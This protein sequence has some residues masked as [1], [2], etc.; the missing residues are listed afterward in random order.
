MGADQVVRVSLGL[1]DHCTVL[2]QKV[3]RKLPVSE[4]LKYLIH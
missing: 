1:N 4:T 2:F 3:F